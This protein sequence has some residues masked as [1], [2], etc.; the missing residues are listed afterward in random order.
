[1][2][3][4]HVPPIT[5]VVAVPRHLGRTEGW[6]AAAAAVLFVALT[7]IAVLA[8]A[9]DAPQPATVRIESIARDVH[10]QQCAAVTV[11]SAEADFF[12]QTAAYLRSLGGP[13]RETMAAALVASAD[14]MQA[15][16]LTAAQAAVGC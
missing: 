4:V 12:V 2:T 14:R 3:A 10:E 8:L 9:R 1:M 6:I 5:P 16:A 11:Q 15:D 13:E 7:A